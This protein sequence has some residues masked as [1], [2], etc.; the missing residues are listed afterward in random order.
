MS[1]F[2]IRLQLH[3]AEYR[4][5]TKMT[6]DGNREEKVKDL[7]L[8]SADTRKKEKKEGQGRVMRMDGVTKG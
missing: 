8:C 1:L 3:V 4:K 7:K 6:A 2:C 5:H